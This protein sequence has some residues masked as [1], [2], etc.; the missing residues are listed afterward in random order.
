MQVNETFLWLQHLNMQVGDI[1]H[2]YRFSSLSGHRCVPIRNGVISPANRC[3]AG[4]FLFCC[5]VGRRI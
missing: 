4:V 3:L 5:R 2:A 1:L